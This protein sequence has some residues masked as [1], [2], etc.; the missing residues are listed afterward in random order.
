[1][2]LQKLPSHDADVEHIQRYYVNTL[3]NVDNSE[4]IAVSNNTTDDD[5]VKHYM[6]DGETWLFQGYLKRSDIEVEQEQED[7]ECDND[8]NH[9]VVNDKDGAPA[10]VQQVQTSAAPVS[11]IKIVPCEAPK[12]G[13]KKLMTGLLAL[14]KLVAAGKTD[15]AM[16]KI[17]ALLDN[18]DISK[19]GQKKKVPTV[20]NKF[21]S[22]HMAILKEQDPSLNASE[23]MRLTVAQ[24]NARKAQIQ[25]N[26]DSGAIK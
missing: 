6:Y 13:S 12:R 25:D 15:K 10:P 17:Q 5:R 3:P 2:P 21:V 8:N 24:W 14:S 18:L 7:D 1:M 9:A 19:Q 26:T 22:E 20:Y 23:R 4:Y 16:L 11:N